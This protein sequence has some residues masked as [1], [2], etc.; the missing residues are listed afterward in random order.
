MVQLKEV[1]KDLDESRA[2]REDLS[3][4]VKENEKKLKQLEADFL[5]M[6][7]DLAAAERAR[8]T[9]EQ[10]RDELFEELNS[11]SSV[12][13]AIA[14]ERKRWEAQIAALEEELE[15]ERTQ[16]ELMQDKVRIKSHVF[17]SSVDKSVLRESNKYLLCI[18]S[19]SQE[20]LNTLR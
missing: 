8:R 5:Q 9:I 6:Q 10:E 14:E 18:Y 17:F 12:K 3:G 4:Q 13:A 1:Q 11:N 16:T 20:D 2:T 19:P 15:E 7:E